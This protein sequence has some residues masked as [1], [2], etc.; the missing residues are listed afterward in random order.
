MLSFYL[1]HHQAWDLLN[2]YLTREML[3]S[4][5][6]T[7]LISCIRFI[8]FSSSHFILQAEFGSRLPQI[9]YLVLQ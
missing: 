1:C 5:L 8:D 6:F 3:F 4:V 2:E 9:Q 7:F